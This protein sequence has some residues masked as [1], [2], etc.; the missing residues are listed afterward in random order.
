M[1]PNETGYRSGASGSMSLDFPISE[2]P[3][4]PPR[5]RCRLIESRIL[6]CIPSPLVPPNTINLDDKVS[7]LEYKVRLEPL[8]H[9]LMHL[10]SDPTLLQLCPQDQFDVCQ[11]KTLLDARLAHFLAGCLRQL[12]SKTRLSDLLPCLWRGRGLAMRGEGHPRSHFWSTRPFNHL[13]TLFRRYNAPNRAQPES[14]PF[15]WRAQGPANK[16]GLA[17]L[18]AGFGGVMKSFSSSCHLVLNYNTRK[19]S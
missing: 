2:S 13:G 9:G 12:L 4:R 15:L 11:R 19:G 8:E 1:I 18:L 17:H 5:C 10:E 16:G 3:D 7:A 6:C 14:V